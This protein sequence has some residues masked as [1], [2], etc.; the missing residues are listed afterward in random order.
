MGIFSVKSANLYLWSSMVQFRSHIP[1][2]S[3]SNKLRIVTITATQVNLPGSCCPVVRITTC[4]TARLTLSPTPS[5][6]V[7]CGESLSLLHCYSPW[8]RGR[9]YGLKLVKI[10]DWSPLRL[11]PRSQPLCTAWP[12]SECTQRVWETMLGDRQMA[13][14]VEYHVLSTT[15]KHCR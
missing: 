14:F 15:C 4:A 1:W 9:P 2:I 13:V 8:S 6:V 7:W 11:Q 5:T 3:F 10:A 12:N